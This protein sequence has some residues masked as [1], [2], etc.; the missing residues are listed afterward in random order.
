MIKRT[1]ALSC[2]PRPRASKAADYIRGFLL[3]DLSPP[4]PPSIQ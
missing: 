3:V 4:L 1:T 2:A